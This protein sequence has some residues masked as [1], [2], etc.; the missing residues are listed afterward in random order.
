MT[1]LEPILAYFKKGHSHIGVVTK[2]ISHESKDPE[3]TKIGII[4]LED[5]I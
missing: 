2:I 3:V 1:K 4:T 5:I